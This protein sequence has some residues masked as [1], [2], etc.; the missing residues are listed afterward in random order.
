MVLPIGNG[1][2]STPLAF[3]DLSGPYTRV[4]SG[5]KA[6][7]GWQSGRIGSEKFD[8]AGPMIR[9]QPAGVNRHPIGAPRTTGVGLGYTLRNSFGVQS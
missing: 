6:A 8:W 1:G 4:W 3:T 7:S 9:H 5:V 2:R